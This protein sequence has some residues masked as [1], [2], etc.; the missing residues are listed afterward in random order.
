M[1]KMKKRIISLM[2]AFIMVFSLFVGTGNL[3]AS[4]DS[5]GESGAD[6]DTLLGATPTDADPVADENEDTEEETTTEETE[7]SIIGTV[8][9]Y[10]ETPS[11]ATENNNMAGIQYGIYKDADCSDL[12][13]TI[14]LSYDGHVYRDGERD[15][16]YRNRDERGFSD[17]EISNHEFQLE[18]P[19]S[20]YYYRIKSN[21]KDS[22]LDFSSTG[23]VYADRIGSFELTADNSPLTV[24]IRDD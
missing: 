13:D 8:T 19:V 7:D 9:F 14:V 2:M 11:A 20:T 10:K 6:K 15:K 4:D 5:K 24:K 18:L 16:V 22:S 21:L 17:S 12:I 3:S 23:Y 1:K